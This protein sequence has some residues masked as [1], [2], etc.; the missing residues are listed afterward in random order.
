[1]PHPRRVIITGISGGIG[2]ATALAFAATGAQVAGLHID[3]DPA[4]STTLT[5]QIR[6]AGGEAV[7]QHGST[8]SSRAVEELATTVAGSWGGIDVWINN[9]A[10]LLVKPFLDTT[11]DDWDALLDTNLMGYVRGA[12]AAAHHM[13][14]VGAGSIINI[15]SVVETYPPAN[16]TAYVAA[17]GAI[18]GLTRALAVELGP[19]GITVNAIAPGATETP[20]NTTSWTEKV[21]DTYRDRIPLG[22]IAQPDDIADAIVT[23]ASHHARYITGQIIN[24]DGGLTLNGT[25]GHEPAPMSTPPKERHA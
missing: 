12:R 1:M 20:L 15:G 18:S 25:V 21:R 10:R 8:T 23:F 16:M 3:T 11:D 5:D 9:A 6:A 24:V 4:V 13:V 2:K 17:K 14:P 22:R 7:I 19:Y